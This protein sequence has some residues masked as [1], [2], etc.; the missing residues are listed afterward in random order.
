MEKW[1]A[2]PGYEGKYEASNK[3]KIRSLNYR[4]H[5][6]EVREL[7][8]TL[9]CYGYPMVGLYSGREKSTFRNISVHRLIASAWLPNPNNL[10]EIDHINTIRDDNRVENLRWCT[11]KE[12]R[13]NVLTLERHSTAHSGKHRENCQYKKRQSRAIIQY[14]RGF[15]T[16]D[17]EIVATYENIKAA[18]AALDVSIDAIYRACKTGGTCRSFYL[19]YAES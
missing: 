19:K 12:N 15:F 10:P 18:A 2:I 8:Q 16:W 5:P 7:R 1:K 6:G 13:N 17:R 11:K 3:G 9:N 4:G 14:K